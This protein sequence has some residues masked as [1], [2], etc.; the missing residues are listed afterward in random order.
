MSLALDTSVCTLCR[1]E[2]RD[3][4]LL[5][6]WFPDQQSVTNWGGPGFRYPFTRHSFAEDLYWRRMDSFS[7]R[8]RDGQVAAF[9]Q[10]YPRDGRIHL[11][12]L[13]ADPSLRGQGFGRRLIAELMRQGRSMFACREAS[14]FVFRDNLAACRCY[15]SMGFTL[16]EYPENMPYADVCDYLTLSLPV[17][18]I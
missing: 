8:D 2:E 13:V 3:I 5:M 9:G 7:L 15:R 17:E 4:D 12:R 16:A 6:K 11:A 14:L 18:E 10:L 1:A